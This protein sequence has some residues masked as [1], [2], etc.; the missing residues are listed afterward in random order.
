[1][2]IKLAVLGLVAE[3]PDHGYAIRTRFEERMGDLVDLGS[4][5]IYA[6]LS[7]L[8]RE[9]LVAV[10]AECTG[11]RSRRVYSIRPEGRRALREWSDG[12]P[13]QAGTLRDLALG[14]TAVGSEPESAKRMVVAWTAQRRRVI[15]A[16]ERI[17]PGAALPEVLRV[18]R[19][20][21]QALE[22]DGATEAGPR[23]AEAVTQ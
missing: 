16:L 7:R 12:L 9:G 2:Y 8:E 6:L 14:L 23:D 11:R 5:R 21:A 17:G 15:E 10:R 18:V 3:R 19:E 13:A 22:G 20:G 1:M 4:G